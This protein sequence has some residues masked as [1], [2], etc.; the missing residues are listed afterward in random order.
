MSV[1]E[2]LILWFKDFRKEKIMKSKKHFKL[3]FFVAAA[4]L[5]VAIALIFM[6]ERCPSIII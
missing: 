5:I 2:E 1:F 3:S 4:F 6:P